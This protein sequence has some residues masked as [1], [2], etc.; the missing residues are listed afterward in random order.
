MQLK[1]VTLHPYPSPIHFLIAI[2]LI[3]VHNYTRD[4]GGIPVDQV[5]Q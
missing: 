4:L 2:S 3:N 1:H 5:Q